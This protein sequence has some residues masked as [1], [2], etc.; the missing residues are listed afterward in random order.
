[1]KFVWV[2]FIHT[3]DDGNILNRVFTKE[4]DAL[5]YAKDYEDN[6]GFS[7]NVQTRKLNDHYINW[8][9]RRF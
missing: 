4:K 1:M 3:R 7:T 6:I 5:K 2:V 9:N 8:N